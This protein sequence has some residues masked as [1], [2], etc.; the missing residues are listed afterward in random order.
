[1]LNSVPIVNLPINPVLTLPTLGN[2]TVIEAGGNVSNAFG[3]LS[4]S[5]SLLLSFLA[6]PAVGA[7][8][9]LYTFDCGV[10]DAAS[11]ADVGLTL[12]ISVVVES[13]LFVN[14][15][16]YVNDEVTTT[17]RAR[18]MSRTP[19]SPSATTCA[20]STSRATTD[21]DGRIIFSDLPEDI[22]TV[23]ASAPSH[24]S[25]SGSVVVAYGMSPLSIL[26]G[27]QTVTYSFVV[28]PT[29]APDVYTVTGRLRPQRAGPGGGTHAGGAGRRPHPVGRAAGLSLGSSQLQPR[30]GDQLQHHA[31]HHRRRLANRTHQ[32][33]QHH[34]GERQHSHAH[35]ASHWTTQPPAADGC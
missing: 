20:A 12:Q 13:A 18:Q 17:L 31:A 8:R 11:A 23:S 14:F 15:T 26:L 24:T 19:R 6:L 22:H 25:Y 35:S 7:V 16:V 32:H 34:P 2:L 27:Y 5:Q 10:Q 30:A 1:V 21:D 3:P 29:N 33:S 9:G 4:T 28:V